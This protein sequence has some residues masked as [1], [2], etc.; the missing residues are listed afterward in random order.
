[1]GRFVAALLGV[2]FGFVIAHV[3][4]ETPEGRAFFSRSRATLH[5]F[6]E[7]VRDAYRS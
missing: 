3:L 2:V 5:T 6:T 4:N 1:M 7:G